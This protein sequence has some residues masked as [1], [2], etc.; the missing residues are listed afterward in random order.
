M[1][2]QPDSLLSLNDWVVHEGKDMDIIYLV[3][4]KASDMVSHYASVS[5]FGQYGLDMWTTR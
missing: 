3:F 4:S 2:D 5:E 1:P